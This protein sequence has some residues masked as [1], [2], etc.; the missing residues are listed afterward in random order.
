MPSADEIREGQ[1]AAW[2]GLAAGWEKWDA[3]IMDQLRP[4]GAAMI[5]RLRI[6]SDQQHLDIAS[7]TGEPGL[8][9]AAQARQGRVVLTDLAAEMLAVAERR[10]RRARTRE[11]RDGSVQRR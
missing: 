8:S 6:A 11:H 2:A 3:V 4:V 1:R 9:I 7:G 5:E 10:A